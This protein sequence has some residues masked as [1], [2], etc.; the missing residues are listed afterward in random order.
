M[1][2]SLSL[3]LWILAATLLSSC[4]EADK[5]AK[6]FKLSADEI[7]P[8]ATG[9]GG[10]FAT[11][12]ITVEGKNVGYMYREAADRPED[13]GWRFFPAKKLRRTSITSKTRAFT[14]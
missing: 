12:E 10:C 2:T 5:N 11:D 9:Y 7:K 3:A 8:L 14:T 1:R 4:S 13:S 6:D